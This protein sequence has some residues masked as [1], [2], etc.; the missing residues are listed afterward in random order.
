[1]PLVSVAA[2]QLDGIFLGATLGRQMR[3]AMIVSLAVYLGSCW[4]MIPVWGNHGLWLSLSAFMIAPR[5]KPGRALPGRHPCGRGRPRL[6]RDNG[7]PGSGG[8]AKLCPGGRRPAWAG[9]CNVR[10]PRGL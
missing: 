3:N 5:R 8:G 1:M 9:E 2:F 4:T 10:R 7:L 6:N